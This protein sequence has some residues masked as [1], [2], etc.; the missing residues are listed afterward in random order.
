MSLKALAIATVAT[1]AFTS[2]AAFAESHFSKD[3]VFG[4]STYATTVLLAEQGINATSVEGWGEVIRVEAA[5]ADGSTKL[6]FVDKDT[7]RPVT[8]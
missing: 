7:L 5:D 3:E 2:T 8:R 6:I 1:V 4:R